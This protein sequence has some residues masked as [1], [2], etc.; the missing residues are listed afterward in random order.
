MIRN[1][2]YQWA[3]RTY[4]QADPGEPG[5][6]PGDPPADPPPGDPPADPP[7]GDPPA[8]PPENWRTD[9]A[10]DN[11]DYAK[12]LE[13]YT[14]QE[15]FLKGSFQAHDKIRAGETQYGLG[16]DASEEQVKE[17]RETNGIP[18]DG[19]Y[20]IKGEVSELDVEM[21]SPVMAY[22][23]EHNIS[24]DDLNGLIGAYFGSR[25]KLMDDMR[26]QDGLDKQEFTRVMKETWGGEFETNMNRATNRFN[27][28]PEADREYIKGA[29][30]EDGQAITNNPAFM[31]WLVNMDR[32]ISPLA[33][34]P[35]AS[36]STMA[37][38]HDI[39]KKAQ[40]RMRD[41]SVE[42]HRD[43]KAQEEYQRALEMRDK[44]EGVQ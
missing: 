12:R 44:Y 25:D 40:D 7:P 4:R 10:G 21:L 8:D 20:E 43:T 41:D 16:E 32:E 13:R 3:G 27:L 31:S 14:T 23:H 42:W 37:D 24:G 6:A 2:E 15:D 9:L 5:A 17:Y 34:L 18:L 22:A 26:Q 30:T 33:P 29:K 19:K 35:G 11:E 28:L 39:I 38:A 36:E 1:S